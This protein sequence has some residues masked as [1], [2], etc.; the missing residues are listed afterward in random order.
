[1]IYDY[2]VWHEDEQRAIDH[3]TEDEQE[4][5]ETAADYHRAHGIWPAIAKYPTRT[6]PDG[7]YQTDTSTWEV[8]AP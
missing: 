2:N 8:I 5:R 1:M 6:M 7:T 4:A 3:W